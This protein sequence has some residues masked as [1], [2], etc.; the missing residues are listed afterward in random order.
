[1]A[2]INTSEIIN[3]LSKLQRNYTALAQYWF[4]MFYNEEPKQISMEYYDEKGDDVIITIDNLAMIRRELNGLTGTGEPGDLTAKFGTIY[5]DTELGELYRYVKDASSVDDEAGYWDKIISA[6]MLNS[7]IRAG[8]DPVNSKVNCIEGILYIGTDTK[9]LYIGRNGN[10]ERIDAS[11]STMIQDVFTVESGSTDIVDNGHVLSTA[12]E[13]KNSMSVFVDG[14]L[15]SPD[16]YRLSNHGFI[17]KFLEPLSAPSGEVE[18]IVKYSTNICIYEDYWEEE[19]VELDNG[20]GTVSTVYHRK[21][22]YAKDLFEELKDIS[23]KINGARDELA[24][25]YT[26]TVVDGEVVETG[27]IPELQD[28]VSQVRTELENAVETT[29]ISVTEEIRT[30]ANNAVNERNTIA[31]YRDDVNKTYESVKAIQMD[32][33][34]TKTDISDDIV[35]LKNL[36]TIHQTGETEPNTEGLALDTTIQDGTYSL[37]VVTYNPEY[38]ERAN[39]TSYAIDTMF[40]IPGYTDF[41]FRIKNSYGQIDLKR[42]V[43]INN[44]N[45]DQEEFKRTYNTKIENLNT[46]LNTE[47][48]NINGNIQSLNSYTA[49][50]DAKADENSNR[51]TTV[52][53]RLS[54]TEASLRED[55]FSEY[56]YPL[57]FYSPCKI[58]KTLYD[59]VVELPKVDENDENEPTKY[60]ISIDLER[61]CSYYSID[62][63]EDLKN[64]N[65]DKFYKTF[66]FNNYGLRRKD[67]STVDKSRISDSTPEESESEIAYRTGLLQDLDLSNATLG[68]ILEDGDFNIKCIEYDEEID[69]I[70]EDN[71]VYE[72]SEDAENHV[73]F[74]I[75]NYNNFSFEIVSTIEVSNDSIDSEEGYLIQVRVMITNRSKFRPRIVWDN[76]AITWLGGEEPD[77]EAGNTYLL[78]FISYD[79]GTSWFAHVLGICQPSI[80]TTNVTRIFDIGIDN[81]NS[82]QDLNQLCDVFYTKENGKTYYAGSYIIDNGVLRDVT[83][84][85]ERKELGDSFSN[86]RV[87]K[88]SDDLFVKHEVTGISSY[89]IDDDI[90]PQTGVNRPKF[91]NDSTMVDVHKYEIGVD[92]MNLP[93]GNID[94]VFTL[95]RT[96]DST[97]ATLD[98]EPIRGEL[99]EDGSRLVTISSEDMI[100]AFVGCDEKELTTPWKI[101]KV[102]ATKVVTTEESEEENVENIESVTSDVKVNLKLDGYVYIELDAEEED[103]EEG[104]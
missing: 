64:N 11:P 7:I 101:T 75:E 56:N 46:L 66:V 88:E 15:Y 85:F 94:F 80:K 8:V 81:Y 55:C 76:S 52:D 34:S 39:N 104:E 96:V 43:F 47:V 27:V 12:C 20:D 62:L 91:D 41:S 5:H 99:E 65:A 18:V 51:I 83:L 1:M 53:N 67:F 40:N 16:K 58:N 31:K 72:V 59:A 4:D 60:G 9:K 78:E 70:R 13:S 84:T 26:R 95:E 87:H 68:A 14:V 35:W 19:A 42:F 50:I 30:I 17:L 25:L 54:S 48:N 103:T 71:A 23:N 2:D 6:N 57:G 38:I 10:W 28:R 24:L 98:T 44:Y 89:L 102:V 36:F 100:V 79:F 33:S 21:F 45:A 3:V 97:V 82:A 63:T 90:E 73:R 61:D 69:V 77:L 49:S 74:N 37:L 93:S 86:L 32:I 22:N 29:T 92:E